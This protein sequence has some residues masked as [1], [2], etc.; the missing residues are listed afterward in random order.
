M[1]YE[2]AYIELIEK[3]GDIVLSD[4]YVVER[5]HVMPKAMGGSDDA[6]NLVYLSLRAHLVA[7]H[8]LMKIYN[9]AAM[10]YAYMMMCTR[11]GIKL[12]SRMYETFREGISGSNHFKARGVHTPAGNFD[13]LREAA[14]AMQITTSMISMRCKS[15]FFKFKE[16]YYIDADNSVKDKPHGKTGDGKRVHTPLGWFGSVRQAAIAHG[17]YHSTISKKCRANESEY[18]YEEICATKHITAQRKVHTPSGWFDS[19]A[20]AAREMGTYPGTISSRCKAGW[21]DYYYSEQN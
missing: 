7:H 1:N 9:N 21:K 12:T 3:H 16:Y 8:F 10:R 13:T 17:V 11:D 4:E 18:F 19:V 15:G 6:S 20:M 14:T 2:K 5:H